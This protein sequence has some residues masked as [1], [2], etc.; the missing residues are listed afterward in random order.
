VTVKATSIE[1]ESDRVKPTQIEVPDW[2]SFSFKYL[3]S[4]KKFR[5]E[6]KNRQ[7]FCKVIERFRSLSAHTP[8][9]LQESRSPSLK[10]HPIKWEETSEGGFG[11]PREDQIV[12]LDGNIAVN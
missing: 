3:K 11:I 9:K 8:I 2:L 4:T 7:Y 1:K 12:D 5:Y 6:S 10:C